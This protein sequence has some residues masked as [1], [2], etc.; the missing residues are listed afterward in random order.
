MPL[1]RIL[2]EDGTF[3]RSATEILMEAYNRVVTD[4]GL[5]E[6]EERAS[7]AKMI[8]EIARETGLDVDRLRARVAEIL[9]K[10]AGP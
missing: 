4:F 9:K 6:P 3:G 10:K 7:A 2:D 1:K 8:I 5:T